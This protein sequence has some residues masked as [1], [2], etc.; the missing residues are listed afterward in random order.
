VRIVRRLFGFLTVV[1]MAVAAVLV[2]RRRGSRERVDVYYEDGS[3][4]TVERGEAGADALL[5]HARAALEA[6]RG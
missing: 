2:L 5:A 1:G 3:M 6:A 4:M